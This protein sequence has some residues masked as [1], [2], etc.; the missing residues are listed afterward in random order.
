VL[1]QNELAKFDA[2]Q[3]R[4]PVVAIQ[5]AHVGFRRAR[6]R[7][8]GRKMRMRDWFRTPIT[9]AKEEEDWE[10]KGACVV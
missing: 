5:R 8:R 9:A 2:T 1:V 3:P 6:Y 10:A 7:T 4:R